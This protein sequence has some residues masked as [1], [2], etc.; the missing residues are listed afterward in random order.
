MVG[1]RNLGREYPRAIL[2]GARSRLENCQN[3]ILEKLFIYYSENTNTIV[4]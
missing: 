4:I 1:I 2:Q 3:L